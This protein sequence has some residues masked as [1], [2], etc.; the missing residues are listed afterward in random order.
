VTWGRAGFATVA[1]VKRLLPAAL[2]LIVAVVAA[3]CGSSESSEPE[4][5]ADWANGVCTAVTTWTDSV[6]SAADPLTGGDISKDSLQSAA[7]DV[8][9]ATATLE[10][11]LKDLG[12]P[13]TESGQEAKDAID[14]LSSEL[15]TGTD[16][17]KDAVDGVSSISGIVG[18]V[19][20]IGTTLATMQSQVTSTYTTLKGLDAKG[21]LQDAFEQASACQQLSSSS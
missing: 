7:E 11:D 5:A 4:T 9:S 19:A 6:K 10:S 2:L 8:K 15:M 12:K 18:A 17:I 1:R 14:Q 21:E 13:D 16:S 20:T 3:G